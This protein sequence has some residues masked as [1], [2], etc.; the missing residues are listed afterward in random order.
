M[1]VNYSLE[2]YGL[3]PNIYQIV[4][5]PFTRYK[6]LI[7]VVATVFTPITELP[8]QPFF[9]GIYIQVREPIVNSKF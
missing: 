4:F 5:M 9:T 7:V 8:N 1:N 3:Y 2:N 6:F